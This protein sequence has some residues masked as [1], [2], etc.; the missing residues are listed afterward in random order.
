[1]SGKDNMTYKVYLYNFSNTYAAFFNN[2]C[3]GETK[4]FYF[5]PCFFQKFIRGIIY[6]K[7][8]IYE[9]EGEVCCCCLKF[10]KTIKNRI[11]FSEENE[12]YFDELNKMLIEYYYVRNA[13]LF[14][15]VFVTSKV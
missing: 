1:M 15:D 6:K 3:V 13:N 8:L 12:G 7:S 10:L 2:V 11:Y 4:C 5:C 9:N 14:A